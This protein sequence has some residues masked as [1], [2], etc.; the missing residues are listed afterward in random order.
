MGGLIYAAEQCN[1]S[2]VASGVGGR[3][4]GM[5]GRK[6]NLG[7]SVGNLLA[8]CTY[9]SVATGPWVFACFLV[10]GKVHPE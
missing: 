2:P 8:V 3:S 9:V 10:S 4:W 5:L 6:Q 7:G 1:S